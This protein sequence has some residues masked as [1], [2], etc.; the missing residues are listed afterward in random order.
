MTAQEVAQG[1]PLTLNEA[2]AYLKVSVHT[3]HKW[4][5][6]GTI[7]FFKPNGRVLYFK[8]EDLD[9]WVFRNR[10]IPAYEMTGGAK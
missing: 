9:A 10:N 6:R 5:S 8:R 2:A 3:L 7:P 4:T 1:E